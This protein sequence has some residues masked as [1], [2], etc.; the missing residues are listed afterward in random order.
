MFTFWHFYVSYAYIVC[1]YC[2]LSNIHILYRLRCVHIRYVAT[3]FTPC[4]WNLCQIGRQFLSVVD[5]SKVCTVKNGSGVSRLQPGCHYQTLP[6]QELW[7]H[8]WIIPAQGE[9]GKWHPGWRRETR[10]PF[11]TVWAYDMVCLNQ[12]CE[13]RRQTNSTCSRPRFREIWK[14]SSLSRSLPLSVSPRSRPRFG[15]PRPPHAENESSIAVRGSRLHPPPPC[16]VF[17]AR[18]YRKNAVL[19]IRIRD[20]GSGIRD[21]VLFDPW[22]RD[23]E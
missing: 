23:P 20:P 22:I 6:G 3:P 2:T 13:S 16:S 12:S 4:G 1:S 9:F 14:V 11:F 21:W 8:N 7:R 17:S 10:E 15:F 19:R 18:I 5:N